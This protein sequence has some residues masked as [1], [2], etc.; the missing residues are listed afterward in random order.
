MDDSTFLQTYFSYKL[1]K[2][3]LKVEPRNKITDEFG[4]SLEG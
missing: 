2:S 3:F 1:N 4:C